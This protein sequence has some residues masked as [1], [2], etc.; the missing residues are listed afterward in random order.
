MSAVAAS[1]NAK[2]LEA[3]K[4]SDDEF[5]KKWKEAR[6]TDRKKK[7]KEEA[8]ANATGAAIPGSGDTGEAFKPTGPIRRR[9]KFAGH[10]TFIVSPGT[11]N[12][13]KEAKR[14]K[15]HWRTYLNED[16]AYH[17]LREYAKNCKGPIIV[18]DERTGACMYVRYGKNGSLN[19]AW[20]N[21]VD[22]GSA[23]WLSSAG[24]QARYTGS[25]KIGNYDKEHSVHRESDGGETHYHLVHNETGTITHSVNGKMKKGVL[26]I[27]GAG[28]IRKN[29]L[30]KIKM[31]DFYHHL[32][33]KGSAHEAS[34]SKEPNRHLVALKGTD[35]SP[36]AQG[37]WQKLAKKSRATVH[38]WHKGKAVNLGKA[39]DPEETHANA[40]S[41]SWS[42]KK[43]AGSKEENEVG[44]TALVASVAPAKKKFKRK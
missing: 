44:Q 1:V 21:S 26:D 13:L 19:E 10:P 35:H 25:K 30:N 20:T 43:S 22:R 16:D 14:M 39:D 11:F 7:L 4:K 17:D 23:S 32:L 36:G 41:Y 5:D 6:E 31:Q 28:S 29:R 37:V 18:E 8:P 15:K 2:R 9:G 34:G 38:G 27:H 42:G 24:A 33:R 40:T 12:S 3:K